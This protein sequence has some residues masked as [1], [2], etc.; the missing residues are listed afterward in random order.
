[1]PMICAVMPCGIGDAMP[2]STVGE[3]LKPDVAFAAI[4]SAVPWQN[5]LK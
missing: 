1:M 3:I 4:P 2:M 5:G